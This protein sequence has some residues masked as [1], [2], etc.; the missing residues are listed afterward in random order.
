MKPLSKLARLA[1]F[2]PPPP[3]RP[4]IPMIGIANRWLGALSPQKRPSQ[5]RR[6]IHAELFP[7]HKGN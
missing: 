3:R 5:N 7:I 4:P 6:Y 1:D 2:R